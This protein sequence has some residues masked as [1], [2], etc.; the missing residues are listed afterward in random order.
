MAHLFFSYAHADYERLNPIHQQMELM[1]ER[2]I[3]IDRIGLQRDTAWESM[4]KRAVESS[5]GVIFAITRDFVN[6]RFIL[7]QEIPWAIERFNNSR[8]G[9]L[10]FPILLDD[11]PLP[12]A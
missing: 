12:D 7:E 9:K 5:Y 10:L 6:R 4:I 11:V 8:Q 3:W 1:T 2:M